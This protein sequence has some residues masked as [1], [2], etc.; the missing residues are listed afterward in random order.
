MLQFHEDEHDCDDTSNE[1]NDETTEN[2]GHPNVVFVEVHDHMQ[3]IDK[4]NENS[5]KSD[6]N[7]E[8]LWVVTN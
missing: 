3:S 5:D 8:V 4:N 6:K 7:C 2:D 1:A